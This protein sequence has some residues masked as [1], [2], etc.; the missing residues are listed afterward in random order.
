MSFLWI[1]LGIIGYLLIGG[2]VYAAVN[3]D[4]DD[5]DPIGIIFVWPMFVFLFACML[6]VHTLKAFGYF[7]VSLFKHYIYEGE[8]NETEE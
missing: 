4:K 8:Q 1:A 7:T 6:V 2:I 5:D 3:N